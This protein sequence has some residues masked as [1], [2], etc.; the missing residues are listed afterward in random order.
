M[1]SL[2]N[3]TSAD[4]EGHLPQ[5]D[6]QLSEE[7]GQ[8]LQ[9]EDQQLLED[10]V[11]L[12]KSYTVAFKLQAVKVAR[13]KSNRAA[14][15]QFHVA[16]K[17]IREWRRQEGQLLGMG[18]KRRR[19]DGGGRKPA[20]GQIEDELLQWIRK[21]RWDRVRVTRN[22]VK[23]Q[24]SHLYSMDSDGDGDGEFSASDG[25]LQNFMKRKGISLRRR[26]TISQQIPR[27]MGQKV[28]S[29]LLT[30]RKLRQVHCYRADQ[31]AAMDE[32]GIWLDMPGNT[33]LEE[34]GQRTVAV[35]ST[36]HEKDRF[37][38][39][40]G[41]RADGS[42]MHP[43]IIFKGK[44]KDKALDRILGVIIQMQENAWMDEELTLKWLRTVW[45]GLAATRERRMLVWD[46]F[47]AH[48]T[49]RVKLCADQICNTDLVIVPV[50]CT[51]LLQAPDISWNKPFK[52]H[53]RELWSTWMA[54]GDKT[55]TRAGK[56]RAP[57]KEKC[58]QWVKE[59]WASVTK[60]TIL[61]SFKSAGI[62]TAINV[63]EDGLIKCLSENNDL[64][65][66]VTLQL[67]GEEEQRISELTDDGDPASEAE[68]IEIF[69]DTDSE[70]EGFTADS[71]L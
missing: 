31:I 52:E 63:S 48:R 38:V 57:T 26:T 69:G 27:E 4:E 24:A 49:E 37:T 35:K 13:E 51:A 9:G 41:A 7:E 22:M 43:M 29:H 66:E 10:Q 58:A 62:T 1:F 59:A 2:L 50:G 33:S 53:Y 23:R 39:V 15:R 45:G 12:R 28:A 30:I 60:E 55:Y 11:H 54:S 19:L 17:R 18:R 36:G 3:M 8:I 56:M 5:E 46:E 47:K 25:W 14:A 42:K 65:K 16:C 34:K 61:R 32:T 70:F 71:L 21:L 40:L 67:Y 44:R 68:E 20:I 64:A 6:G